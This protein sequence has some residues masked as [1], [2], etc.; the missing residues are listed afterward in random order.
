MINGRSGRGILAGAQL[1][2]LGSAL[3]LALFGILLIYSAATGSRFTSITNHHL[4]Q[5]AWLA[6]GIVAM[7]GAVAIPFTLYEGIRAYVGW[8]ISILLVALVLV[9]GES[10]LGAQRWLSLGGIR[11]QPSEL[12][13]LTTV[14]AL[15][16]Y[17]SRRRRDVMNVRS[18]LVPCALVVVP[19]LLI[20]KQPDLGTAIAFP[21]I[22]IA[23]LYWAGLPLSYLALLTSP[24]ASL[25]AA[26][27]ALTWGLFAIAFVATL[28]FSLNRYRLRWGPVIALCLIN[29]LV[30]VA[31]PQIWGTMKPYQ[32]DRITA[33][34]NPGHD[35]FGSGY[36]IIQSEIAIG[37]GGLLGQ[38]Y[39]Q[40]TQK[41]FQFLP[42]KHTDFVFS[43]A[44]EEFGFAGG[45]AILGL[46]FILFSGVIAIARSARSRFASL[47]AFGVGAPLFFHV[48]I[49][50]AMTMGLAPVTGL[51]LPLVSY[52]GTALVVNLV[53]LGL[54]LGIGLRRH[55]Y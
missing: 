35:R 32:R 17:L 21:F 52:G 7:G 44:G 37:S 29:L 50:V 20:L 55:E 5:L 11:F 54:V 36:Q 9:I 49:N 33:F 46:Y 8:A 48:V 30:G 1:A 24:V 40:G 19:M 26:F 3:L 34:M 31:T 4:R 45:L 27:S 51:P 43:V 25:I 15:A 22:L 39:L 14:V 42:E 18:L 28:S 13:K 12:A 41:N 38:G 6:I 53:G 47:I 10:S 16:Y 2:V 23:M